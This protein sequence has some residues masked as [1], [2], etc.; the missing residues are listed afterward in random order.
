MIS[1]YARRAAPRRTTIFSFYEP[2]L[3]L[4]AAF[5]TL[6]RLHRINHYF[7]MYMTWI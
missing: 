1:C 7:I 6:D 2:S 3:I 4:S 5:A